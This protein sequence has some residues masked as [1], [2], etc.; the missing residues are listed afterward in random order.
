[1]RM[2]TRRSKKEKEEEK[3]KTKK[4]RRRRKENLKILIAYQLELILFNKRKLMNAILPQL[5]KIN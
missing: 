2:R 3:K 4:K 1:M 5:L